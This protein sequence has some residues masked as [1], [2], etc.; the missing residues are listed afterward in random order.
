[1]GLHELG[2]W[3]VPP[4]LAEINLDLLKHILSMELLVATYVQDIPSCLI[5]IQRNPINVPSIDV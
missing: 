5:H 3:K 4:V 1:M 2:G